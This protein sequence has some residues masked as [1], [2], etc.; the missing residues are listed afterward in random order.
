[1]AWYRSSIKLDSFCGQLDYLGF[2]TRF[3]KTYL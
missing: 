2:E 1:M 3:L